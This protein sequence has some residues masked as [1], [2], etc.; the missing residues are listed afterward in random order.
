[1]EYKS[2]AINPKISLVAN[3]TGS[4]QNY[5]SSWDESV[6]IEGFETVYWTYTITSAAQYY[7]LT[8]VCGQWVSHDGS[9]TL[10]NRTNIIKVMG[11][12]DTSSVN[13]LYTYHP[14]SSKFTTTL[15]ST[16][17]FKYGDGGITIMNSKMNIT[18]TRGGTKWSFAMIVIGVLFSD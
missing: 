12:A 8:K 15:T 10:S 5:I 7:K 2:V 9:I 3:S 6:G 1:M 16:P 13:R 11:G 4:G 18:L 17:Q 14:T